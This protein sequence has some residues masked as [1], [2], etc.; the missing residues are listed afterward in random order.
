MGLPTSSP[1]A[2]DLLWSLSEEM[3]DLAPDAAWPVDWELQPGEPSPAPGIRRSFLGTAKASLFEDAYSDAKQAAWRPLTLS[4]LFTDGWREPFI[5]PPPGRGGAPRSGW[6]NSFEGTLFRAWFLSFVSANDVNH[7]GNQYLGGYTLYAPLSRR[8]EF[9]IDLPFVVSNK[10]GTSDSYHNRFGDLVISPRIQLSESRDF[11]QT[12]ALAI[13]N[14][15]GSRVNGQ[16]VASLSPQ[17]Q[18]WCD[19]F[20]TWAVRGARA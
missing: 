10:G 6:V 14:P 2:E 4:S 18:F 8:F 5:N 15:T 9:R 11:S 17:Y 12:I 3:G 1:K 13:R 16:G 19:P 7:N 20:G